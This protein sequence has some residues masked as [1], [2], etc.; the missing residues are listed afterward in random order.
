MHEL[1]PCNK[2]I[3]TLLSVTTKYPSLSIF[4][5]LNILW[6]NQR[7]GIDAYPN[8]VPLKMTKK[9]IISLHC[10]ADVSKSFKNYLT[11]YYL[12][13]SQELLRLSNLLKEDR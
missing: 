13:P 6:R 2:N 3:P 10:I 4:Y 7:K 1:I 5:T 9:N 12:K 11:I 8:E